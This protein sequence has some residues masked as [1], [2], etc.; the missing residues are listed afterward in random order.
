MMRTTKRHAKTGQAIAGSGEDVAGP[1]P[2]I[3]NL[4]YGERDVADVVDDLI[5]QKSAGL[6]RKLHQR[7]SSVGNKAM[8]LQHQRRWVAACYRSGL[9]RTPKHS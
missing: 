7:A 2:V 8:N 3:W 1:T 4:P 6:T 9:S 5:V